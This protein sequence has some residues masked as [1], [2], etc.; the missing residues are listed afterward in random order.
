[1]HRCSFVKSP[2]WKF[3]KKKAGTVR[4]PAAGV[5]VQYSLPPVPHNTYNHTQGLQN[6]KSFLQSFAEFHMF[7]IS[8]NWFL[9]SLPVIIFPIKLQIH[10]SSYQFIHW[11]KSYNILSIFSKILREVRHLFKPAE[12][13]RAFTFGNLMVYYSVFLFYEIQ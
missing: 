7:K 6:E 13:N 3:T 5:T 12:S 9:F 1:M 11:Y 8:N 2:F 4:C 10:Y